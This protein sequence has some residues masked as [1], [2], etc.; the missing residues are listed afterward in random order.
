MYVCEDCGQQ[1]PARTPATRVVVQTVITRHPP[2]THRL[3]G[4]ARAREDR[5]GEG[6][7]IVRE[8]HVCP[9]CAGEP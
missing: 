2:R 7:Q 8:L 4:E 9:A 5:G 6:S 3:R 1:V